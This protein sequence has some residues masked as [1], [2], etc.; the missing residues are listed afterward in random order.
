VL[1]HGLQLEQEFLEP[2]FV[3][4]VDDD[5]QELVVSRWV[6]QHLLSIEDVADMQI[7]AV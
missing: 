3:D 2:E 4:L 1:P 6:A 7:G 5:E